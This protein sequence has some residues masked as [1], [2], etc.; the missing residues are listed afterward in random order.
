MKICLHL[1]QTLPLM[2][3]KAFARQPNDFDYFQSNDIM[4]WNGA[5]A[6][7]ACNG[8]YTSDRTL[9]QVLY[10]ELSISE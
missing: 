5:Q 8:P 9:E 2:L 7:S 4:I 3:S 10:Q 6:L 1:F